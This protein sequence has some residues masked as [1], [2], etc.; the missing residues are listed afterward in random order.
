M[1]NIKLIYAALAAAGWLAMPADGFAQAMTPDVMPPQV[2]ATAQ[3]NLARAKKFAAEGN[4]Q[5]VRDQIEMIDV[6]TC[7]PDGQT[8]REMH[9]LKALSAVRLNAPDALGLLDSY[10]AA[11]PGSASYMEA[12][13][14][15]AD[16]LFFNGDY[17]G[18]L[19]LYREIPEDAFTGSVKKEYSYHKAFCMVKRGYYNEARPI[20]RELEADA[21]YRN[22]AIF[23][24]AYIDYVKGDYDSAYPKFQR[25][26][27][28]SEKGL[29]AEYYI[30]QIDFSRGE[31][32]KVADA[33]KKLLAANPGIE[34]RPETLKSTGI[35]LFKLGDTEG[36]QKYLEEYV[37]IAG[38]GADVTALYTLGTIYYD[39]GNMNAARKLFM[40]VTDDKSD[41]AQS[42]LLYLGQIYAGEDNSQ[43]AAIA[44]DKAALGSWDPKVA[45]KAH[46]N[47]SVS[48]AEGTGTPFADRAAVMEEFIETY[49]RSEYTP[50]VSRYLSA[51]YY[52]EHRYEEALKAL[53][54]IQNPDTETRKERQKVLLQLGIEQL[55]TDKTPQAIKT[56]QAAAVSAGNP[57]I[58]AQ[59]NLWLGDALYSQKEY[60]RAADA[61]K[62]AV[63]SG[64]LGAN[65]ALGNYNLGYTLMKLGKYSDAGEAFRKALA[66]K[67][68]NPTQT[69][70]AKLRLGDCL[71]YTGRYNEAL[72]EFK[73]AGGAGTSQGTYS[74]MRQADILGR[75]GNMAERTAILKQLTNGNPGVWSKEIYRRL[76]SSYAEEGNDREAAEIYGKMLESNLDEG[77]TTEALYALAQNADNL[78]AKGDMKA[79]LEAY[80][81]LEKSTDSEINAAAVIGIM[82]TADDRNEAVAY[83][84]KALELPGV[85]PAV[86]EEA[87]FVI[88]A[89]Q[90]ANGAASEKV[91]AEEALKAL[92]EESTT[93]WGMRAAVALADYYLANGRPQEAEQLLLTIID[94]GSDDSYWLA[95]AY[96]SLADAYKAMGNDY[97]AKLYLETLNANYPGKEQEI[98]DMIRTRLNK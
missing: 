50:T 82:R 2:S 16:L 62:L 77:E 83:A 89:N 35:S 69:T 65:T 68:L 51:A 9:W 36:A 47:L 61:Y 95:R 49:P 67:Q 58:D 8:A 59:A 72:A 53:D 18:A 28:T 85:S 23:Y 63:N 43:A 24:D 60:A 19:E 7:T 12:L 34:I 87:G 75:L 38:E 52:N 81:K 57:E 41:I 91:A 88:A 22:A 54:N 42:A 33:G 94:E 5:G 93:V 6:L 29:E 66:A 90:L 46:Y 39:Q 40:R 17:A 15:K 76:A 70:D 25:V 32:R 21:K 74:Q 73:S 84:R 44:F 80:R 30:N 20:F 86:M 56:L 31:Y 96:I 10:L 98:F 71:Y 3:G 97:L 1:R 27:K 11:Y 26:G 92:A 4:W 64:K 78:M 79:A 14:L 37:D 55:N 45:E 48:A 13:N